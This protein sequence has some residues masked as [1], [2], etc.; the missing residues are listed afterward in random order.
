MNAPVLCYF[1]H[2]VAQRLN[3]SKAAIIQTLRKAKTRETALGEKKETAR[4]FS[5]KITRDFNKAKSAGAKVRGSQRS[6]NCPTFVILFISVKLGFCSSSF[7]NP[8][9][10]PL[11]SLFIS[12][13][14]SLLIYLAFPFFLSVS[15]SFALSSPLSYFI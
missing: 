10:T 8:R 4:S 13:T 1:P 7:T 15:V 6:A 12:Q 14:P 2:I 9:R 3:D 5:G 11:L